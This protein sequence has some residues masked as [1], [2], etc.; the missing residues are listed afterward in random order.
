VPSGRRLLDAYS[1][2]GPPQL[3]A[4]LTAGQ[5]VSVEGW[6]ITVTASGS[7]DTIQVSR[8]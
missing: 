4:I 8:S 7:F 6:T 5:S 3:D 1:C 2:A